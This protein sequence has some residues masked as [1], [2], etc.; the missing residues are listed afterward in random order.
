MVVSKW[1]L[2]DLV[3][4]GAKSSSNNNHI[5]QEDDNVGVDSAKPLFDDHKKTVQC[6]RCGTKG[7]FLK[8]CRKTSAK[9]KEDIYAM[10]KLGNFKTTKNGAVNTT[11]E[12]DP[13]EPKDL[14]IQRAFGTLWERPHQRGAARQS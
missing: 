11:V 1:L 10:M 9:K 4:P 7:N 5:K 8:E 6:H 13:K 2:L 12:E 14:C 3:A